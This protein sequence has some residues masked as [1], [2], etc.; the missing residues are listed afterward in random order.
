MTAISPATAPLRPTTSIIEGG[1]T[2]FPPQPAGP[3]GPSGC[4]N[5]RP[6]PP[7]GGPDICVIPE[8]P[9]HGGPDI[10]VIPEPPVHGGAICIL[11]TPPTG[12]G[13]SAGDLAR[14]GLRNCWDPRTW[15]VQLPS[16]DSPIQ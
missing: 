7:A 10:C 12:R 8:P 16:P 11:P 15:D 6:T 9:V 4:W 5:D 13:E 3:W 1:C 2:P 14:E